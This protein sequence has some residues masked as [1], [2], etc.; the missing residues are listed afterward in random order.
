M[1]LV[2]VFG[3]STV[4][5]TV[6]VFGTRIKAQMAAVSMFGVARQ[7]GDWLRQGGWEALIDCVLKL[8][9]VDLLPAQ[10]EQDLCTY[11]PDLVDP[12]GA[13]PA[14]SGIIPQWWPCE[15]LRR[16]KAENGTSFSSFTLSTFHSSLRPCRKR[17]SRVQHDLDKA[18]SRIAFLV[19]FF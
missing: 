19:G 15:R 6:M 12:T 13:G 4:V 7:S 3:R 5:D 8:H 1:M 16:E 2:A 18:D 11:G 10:L 17:F 9:A 14:P